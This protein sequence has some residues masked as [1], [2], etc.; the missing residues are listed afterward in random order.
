MFASLA[1]IIALVFAPLAST[2][3][4]EA[5]AN[6]S[7]ASQVHEGVDLDITTTND[8]QVINEAWASLDALSEAERGEYALGGNR[9]SVVGTTTAGF[10]T[11]T[12]FTV[13]TDSETY[14]FSKSA[15]LAPMTNLDEISAQ[16]RATLNAN[17]P[18]CDDELYPTNCLI[19]DASG[20]AISVMF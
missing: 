11:E 4:T 12:M 19:E 10:A 15:N 5:Q 14:V 7:L 2:P 16:E 9:V 13:E 6:M 18:S 17:F 8:P 3:N 1:L 20:E